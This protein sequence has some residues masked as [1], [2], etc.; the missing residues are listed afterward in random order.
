MVCE[1]EPSRRCSDFGWWRGTRKDQKIEAGPRRHNGIDM[2]ISFSRLR[3]GPTLD[4]DAVL[5]V[6]G[7][8][9]KMFL[10]A[11]GV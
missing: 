7:G 8:T 11:D 5:A 2:R 9:D 3:P 10:L 1:R 6:L 4:N